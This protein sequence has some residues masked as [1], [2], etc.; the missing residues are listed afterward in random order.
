MWPPW[1]GVDLTR[2]TKERE[3]HRHMYRKSGVG[4]DVRSDGDIPAAAWKLSSYFMDLDWG[5]ALLHIAEEE[6]G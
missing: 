6:A 5:M 2:E 3:T 4:W 1:F